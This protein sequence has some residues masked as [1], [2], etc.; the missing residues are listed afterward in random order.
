MLYFRQI[1]ILFVGLYTVR[2]VLNTLGVVDYGI[3]SVIGGIVTFFSFLRG[4]M[5]SATQRFFSF[6]LGENNQERLKK[7]FSVNLIIY[8]VIAVIA[9]ILLE[10]IGLWFV[11]NKLNVPAERFE[12]ALWIFHFS[13]L[14]FLATIFSTPFMAI[15]IAHEDMQI[16]AYVSIVE[17]FLKLAVVFLLVQLPF[18]KLEVYGVLLFGVSIIIATIYAIVCLRK[19][20]ECQFHHFYWD[21]LL[22]IETI[23][24]TGWTLFGQVTSVTRNQAVTILLNQ[25]FNP[26]VVA[27]RAVAVNVSNYVNVFANNFNTG[28]YPPIIKEYASGNKKNMFALIF[29]GSK[30]AFFLMWV[31]ALP[32]F[33]KMDL[34]LQLWLKNPPL[35]AVLFTRLGLI[36]VLI[37]SVSLPITTAAR[38]PGKM[39]T[40]ELSLGT[41]Q[42]AIFFVDWAILSAGGA[43]YNVFIV[44]IVANLVMFIVRLL[45]VNKLINLPINEFFLK[46]ISPVFIV[47]IASLVPSLVINQILPESLLFAFLTVF[48]SVFFSIISMYFIGF[49]KIWRKKIV[50]MVKRKFSHKR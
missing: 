18:D 22:F 45:I 11:K 7:T 46:V 9:V 41:I 20:K 6:A 14:T 50:D 29:N 35:Q 38:A 40:Y 21:R 24:F 28:L 2:V 48:A 3:Y 5:A 4:T 32:L 10:T 30:I 49:D 1:L 43:A 42:I 27:A 23:G 25:V 37:N 44:A 47:V 34:I 31:F 12:A 17:V 13:I 39:K 8:I 15:I 16:Y 36:E 19:Y 26:V 33:L